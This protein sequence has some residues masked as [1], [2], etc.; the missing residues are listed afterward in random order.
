MQCGN[1]CRAEVAQVRRLVHGLVRAVLQSSEFGVRV[2]VRVGLGL[3]LGLGALLL[4]VQELVQGGG[5]ARKGV[6]VAVEVGL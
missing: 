4:T 2:R 3:G 5:E 1:L 6:A